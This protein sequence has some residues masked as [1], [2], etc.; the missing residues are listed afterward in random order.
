MYDKENKEDYFNPEEEV[1]I[2]GDGKCSLPVSKIDSGESDEDLIYKGRARLFRFRDNEW[3]ERGTGDVKLLRHK[4]QKKIRFL[5]RQDKTLKV[6]ANFLLSEN[7]LCELKPHQG[8]DK[9]FYF[10]AFD[11]SEDEHVVEK[12]V[13]K[14]GNAEKAKDFKEKFEAAKLFNKLVKEG[15]ENELVFAPV[16]ASDD[17]KD[18]EKKEEKKDEKKEEK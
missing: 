11:C 2:E 16:V 8:S 1:K 4:T 10:M 3:K 5:L 6:V 14:L 18:E 7:P 12:F 17:K 13:I 15:K 9:M